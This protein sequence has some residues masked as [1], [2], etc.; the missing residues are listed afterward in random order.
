MRETTLTVRDSSGQ[1]G[2]NDEFLLS[3]AIAL[4]SLPGVYAIACD[5]DGID[6]SEDNAGALITPNMLNQVKSKGLKVLQ[7]LEA[8]D[9]YRFFTALEALVMTGPTLTKVN[10]F[11]AIIVDPELT[12]P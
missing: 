10:D 6:S 1:G 12:N 7:Y 4:D 5:T 3:L 2:R 9:R 11:R 8:H